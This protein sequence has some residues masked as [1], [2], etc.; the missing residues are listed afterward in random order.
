SLCRRPN[1]HVTCLTR[2]RRRCCTAAS[3]FSAAEILPYPLPLFST[4]FLK[5][6]HAQRPLIGD[7][8][9]LD[10][11]QQYERE[12][13]GHGRP[14]REQCPKRQIAAGHFGCEYERNHH[15]A[16]DENRHIRRGVVGA[17]MVE[18]LAADRT[19]VVDLKVAPKQGALPT[20]GT[21]AHEAAP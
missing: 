4:R 17:M 20:V 21:S 16:D 3:L 12:N 11:R 6:V 7:K 13:H 15:M 19:A 1:S 9:A 2:F 10:A 8:C 5:A 18:L 14:D